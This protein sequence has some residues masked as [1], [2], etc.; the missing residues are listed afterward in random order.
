VT[1]KAG[2]G[3][4]ISMKPAIKTWNEVNEL[5]FLHITDEQIAFFG[6]KEEQHKLQ[7]FRNKVVRKT[8]ES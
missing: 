6:M 2:T 5:D 1:L 7:I 4:A 8:S 3:P